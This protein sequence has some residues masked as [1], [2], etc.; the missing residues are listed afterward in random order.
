MCGTPRRLRLAHL[1][2]GGPSAQTISLV[3]VSG[4]YVLAK[5]SR[6]AGM[7]GVWRDVVCRVRKKRA[8]IGRLQAVVFPLGA[9][10]HVGT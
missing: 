2:K 9:G 7:V 8:D 5:F 4:C 10:L 3:T 1:N 6:R